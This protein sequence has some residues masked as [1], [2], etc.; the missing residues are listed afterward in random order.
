MCKEPEAERV[1]WEMSNVARV[2][3]V[4]EQDAK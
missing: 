2:D 3:K 1:N 4:G